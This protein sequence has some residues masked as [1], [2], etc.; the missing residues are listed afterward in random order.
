MSRTLTA[1]V[2]IQKR[3][4]ASTMLRSVARALRAIGAEHGFALRAAAE[5][6][7]HRR[8]HEELRALYTGRRAAWRAYATK[9]RQD[10]A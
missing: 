1:N 8:R 10:A 4:T 2:L 6:E 5:A 9:L 7:L 3:S